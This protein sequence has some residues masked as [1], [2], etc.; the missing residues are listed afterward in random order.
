VH[1]LCRETRIVGLQSG[2][3]IGWAMDTNECDRH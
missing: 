1:V 3:M 2:M